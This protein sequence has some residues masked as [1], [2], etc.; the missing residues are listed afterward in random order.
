M[1]RA[2]YDF[3]T[4]YFVFLLCFWCMKQR[5]KEIGVLLEMLLILSELRYRCQQII[6]YD[7]TVLMIFISLNTVQFVHRVLKYL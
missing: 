6:K 2:K 7:L 1:Q 3:Y 5:Y 4:Q